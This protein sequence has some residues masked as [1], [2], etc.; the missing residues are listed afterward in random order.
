MMISSIY[1]WLGILYDVLY[2]LCSKKIVD[3]C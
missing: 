2:S 1:S 3:F